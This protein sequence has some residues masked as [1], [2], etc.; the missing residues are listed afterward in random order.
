MRRI[1]MKEEGL[2]YEV[3]E[4]NGGMLF[5]LISNQSNDVIY[6]NCSYEYMETGLL[7]SDIDLLLE[8]ESVDGWDTNCEMEAKELYSS[9]EVLNDEGYALSS[10]GWNIVA[11]GDTKTK[12]KEVYADLM[13]C[14][15]KQEFNN[16]EEDNLC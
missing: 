9:F 1:L 11:E 8:D 10:P 13:G 2:R 6:A 3:I 5:L 7:L 12:V 16:E 15:A 4:D 14:S